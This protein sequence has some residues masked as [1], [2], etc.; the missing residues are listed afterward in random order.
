MFLQYR[1]NA[2]YRACT[3]AKETF[4]RDENIVIHNIYNQY[5]EII[6]FLLLL[7][8]KSVLYIHLNM[9]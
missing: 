8:I 3:T 1:N 5:V 4:V 6:K 2:N 9:K 7:V